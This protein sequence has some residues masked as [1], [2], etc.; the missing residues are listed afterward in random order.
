LRSLSGRA[1]AYYFARVR[2]AAIPKGEKLSDGAAQ[3]KDLGRAS[4]A[5]IDE[6]RSGFFTNDISAPKRGQDA[7]AAKEFE[8]ER[9][10]L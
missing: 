5:K 9:G 6:N 3:V 2:S 10:D 4:A 1:L 7:G 8:N